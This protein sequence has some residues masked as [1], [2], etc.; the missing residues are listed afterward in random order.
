[1]PLAP[2]PLGA[3]LARD[4]LEH[5]FERL[6]VEQRAVIVLRHF[7]DLKREDV[8]EALGVPVGTV[9]SRLSRAMAKLRDAL[10]AEE[11]ISPAISQEVAS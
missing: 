1:V 5:A 8:A 7:L 11:P 2:D 4:Q 10:R 6:T 9:D 3:V